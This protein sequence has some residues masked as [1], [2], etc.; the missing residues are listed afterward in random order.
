MSTGE[1]RRSQSV[2]SYNVVKKH[3]EI[4]NQRPGKRLR[5]DIEDL[6]PEIL[7]SQASTS[8]KTDEGDNANPNLI[9]TRPTRTHNTDAL[10]IKL[11][12][13]S[14]K[15]ARYNFHKD[16]LSHCI[17]ERLLP[18]GLDFIVEPTVGNYDQEF[19]ENWYFNLK[20][21]S[22]ILVKQI[23]TYWE[24]TEEKTQT[25]ITEV[26]ATLKQQ[27]KKYGYAEKQNTIK[28]N[29]TVTKQ[30]LHQQKFKKFNTMKYKPKPVKT[31]NFTEGNN[32]CKTYLCQNT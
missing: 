5:G 4:S 23:V 9:T 2:I 27:L 3:G 26:E 1:A 29:E 20:N 21:S 8:I 12:P 22:L 24:K 7:V 11:N 6:P 32:C 28:G 25:S 16:F 18:K 10:A 19:I 30:I 14:K 17:Q 31:T 15:S 13:L